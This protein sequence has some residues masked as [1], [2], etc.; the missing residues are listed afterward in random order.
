MEDF[1][2]RST[3]SKPA[4]SGKRRNSWTFV[5]EKLGDDLYALTQGGETSLGRRD[6]TKLRLM[7]LIGGL[8]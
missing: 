6:E 5:I 7:E 8:L 3:N 1:T 2:C 4:R